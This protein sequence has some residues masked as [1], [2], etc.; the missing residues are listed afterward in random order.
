MALIAGVRAPSGRVMGHAGACV[1]A[2]EKK[3]GGKVRA[4]EDAGVVITN[5]PSKFGEGMKRLL[6]SEAHWISVSDIRDIKTSSHWD[7]DSGRHHR[8]ITEPSNET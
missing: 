7:A 6:G 8:H 4:L 1:D 2:G 5:H 3:A